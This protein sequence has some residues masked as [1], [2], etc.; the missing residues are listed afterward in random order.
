LT[1][2]VLTHPVP[3]ARSNALGIPPKPRIPTSEGI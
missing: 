1:V 3:K 2:Q